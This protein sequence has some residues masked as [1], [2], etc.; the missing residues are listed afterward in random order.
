MYNI[1]SFKKLQP[2]L[3]ELKRSKRTKSRIGLHIPMFS[4]DKASSEQTFSKEHFKIAFL[5]KE[6]DRF[7]FKRSIMYI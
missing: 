2:H 1:F 7:S 3:V 4:F 6:F 5:E